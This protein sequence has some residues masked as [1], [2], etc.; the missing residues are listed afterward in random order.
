M[1]DKTI[2]ELQAENDA[3]RE[4]NK[5]LLGEV[6]KE[7][8]KARDLESQAGGESEELEA[9]RDEVRELKLHKPVREL[10]SKILVVPKYA[11]QEVLEEYKFDLDD[12]GTVVMQHADGTPVMRTPDKEPMTA[13]GPKSVPVNFDADEVSQ[14]LASTGKFD[15]ILMGSKASGGGAPG[16]RGGGPSRETIPSDDKPDKPK[17]AFGLR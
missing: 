9:L 6:K 12:D 2:E 5:E 13:D 3:L 15:H 7:R 14:Y 8:Q 16:G 10:L 1:S 17:P 11:M 4:K